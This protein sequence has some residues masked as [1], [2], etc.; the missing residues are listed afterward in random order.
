[1]YVQRYWSILDQ[2]ESYDPLAAGFVQRWLR[3]IAGIGAF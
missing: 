2:P 3:G 1:M